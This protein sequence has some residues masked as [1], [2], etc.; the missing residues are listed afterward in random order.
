M[1]RPELTLFILLGLP[2]PPEEV[3]W[4]LI[5]YVEVDPLPGQIL[6][7][8]IATSPL[9]AI[10][11]ILKTS[12]KVLDERD[13]IKRPPLIVATVED[14]LDVV[15]LL[16]RYKVDIDEPDGDYATALMYSLS[17]RLPHIARVL[18]KAGAD[19]RWEPT[20]DDANPELNPLSMACLGAI[21]EI[22]VE[23]FPSKREMWYPTR[24]GRKQ[25]PIHLAFL[26][27]QWE[28][29]QWAISDN[30]DIL[31]DNP[32]IEYHIIRECITY[33]A[34]NSLR[35]LLE[36]KLT[37]VDISA[38]TF[39]EDVTPVQ[40]AA[41]YGASKMLRFLLDELHLS[42]HEVRCGSFNTPIR[43][44]VCGDKLICYEILKAAANINAA[45][46]GNED[47]QT[48]LSDAV[49]S[50]H[51]RM[52]KR[53][54]ADGCD[55]NFNLPGHMSIANVCLEYANLTCLKILMDAGLKLN[56]VVNTSNN[57]L[58]LAITSAKEDVA[59]YLYHL[60]ECQA[61][62]SLLRDNQTNLFLACAEAGFLPL[63]KQI[64]IDY[65]E[66]AKTNSALDPT[67]ANFALLHGRFDVALWLAEIGVSHSSK[68]DLALCLGKA[69]HKG[70]LDL[71]KYLLTLGASPR[72]SSE[73]DRSPLSIAAAAGHLE[74]VKYLLSLDGV[75]KNDQSCPLLC[76]IAGG[77]LEAVK[78]LLKVGCSITAHTSNQEGALHLAAQSSSLEVLRYLLNN[79]M[80]ELDIN[81]KDKQGTPLIRAIRAANHLNA[82][83]LLDTGASR[84]NEAELANAAATSSVEC[85][86]L[87]KG[88]NFDLYPSEPYYDALPIEKAA[89]AP[90]LRTFSYLLR[91]MP[92]VGDK[93]TELLQKLSKKAAQAR[94]L[95]ILQ[96]IEKSESANGSL[97]EIFDVEVFNAIS[98]SRAP[99]VM[100]WFLRAGYHYRVD[101]VVLL[102]GLLTLSGSK[103]VLKAAF[104]ASLPNSSTM[105]TEWARYLVS[106]THS[107]STC[108]IA[109]Q[110]LVSRGANIS[111]LSIA[112]LA[113][114]NA[115][116][117]WLNSLKGPII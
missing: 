78:M 76:A 4:S 105:M 102:P 10:E 47:G 21:P 61:S 84:G 5:A 53:L 93:R 18:V 37:N 36:Q 19:I 106:D 8:M 20:A 115:I 111:G 89:G 33:G 77:E 7:P 104:D 11:S 73:R 48:L 99:D 14:R 27:D 100:A 26:F 1:K 96:L 60:P 69:C 113:P 65:P 43:Y 12:P 66:Q 40:V 95:P 44:A 92:F 79:H 2:L 42:P 22:V 83:L 9:S 62:H 31:K 15:E 46:Y 101:P 110:W 81:E 80:G 63:L 45:T 56:F 82:R 24:P 112:H 94:S 51:P 90:K 107:T 85:L 70:D 3:T 55:P 30:R 98:L 91:L 67:A 35:W 49:F 16:L 64:Y 108:L 72:W 68:L 57:P 88:Y 103:Q 50:G 75:D 17:L 74:A 13:S 86:E 38:L 41:G 58:W 29:I 87:L 52:V 116:F 109:L 25:L 23:L 59:E 6:L 39:D 28:F 71:I 34:V 114:G 97:E 32:T 54:L 117:M